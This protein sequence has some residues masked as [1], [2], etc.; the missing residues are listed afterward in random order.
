MRVLRVGDKVRLRDW[1]ERGKVVTVHPEK[2]VTVET[3]CNT[4]RNYTPDA[5]ILL[6]DAGV[7][8]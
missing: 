1:D 3:D 5:F 2:T 6:T 4:Y 7:T 8:E